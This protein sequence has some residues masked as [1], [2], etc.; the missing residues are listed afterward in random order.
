MKPPAVGYMIRMFPQVS[1]TF[2][3]NEVLALERLGTQIQIYSYQRAKE[4]VPHESVG[5]IQAPV[6]YLPDPLYHHP[7]K[8]LHANWAVRRSER[9]VGHQK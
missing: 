1:E 9:R 3:A 6:T 5:L 7:W 4:Y 2:I 8:L